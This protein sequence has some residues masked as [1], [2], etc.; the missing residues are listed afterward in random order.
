MADTTSW[1]IDPA[2]SAVEFAVKQ[3][4]FTTVR[5]RFKDFR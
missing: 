4:M 2:H 3:M 5:G 1:Q